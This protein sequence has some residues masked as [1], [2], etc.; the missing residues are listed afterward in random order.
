MSSNRGTTKSAYKVWNNQD[1]PDYAYNLADSV[2]FNLD[3][4]QATAP[5][6]YQCIFHRLSFAYPT[7]GVSTALEEIKS[8]LVNTSHDSEDWSDNDSSAMS[9]MADIADLIVSHD[10]MS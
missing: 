8:T 7:M 3:S 2:L 10:S 9:A 6:L 1:D 5:S 4:I